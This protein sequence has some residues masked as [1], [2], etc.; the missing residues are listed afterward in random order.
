M[1]RNSTVYNYT[2]GA[3]L[4]YDYCFLDV[5]I[6]SKGGRSV[7]I[8]IIQLGNYFHATSLI[9]NDIQQ[10]LG[11]RA[12]SR[13]RIVYFIISTRRPSRSSFASSTQ[14]RSVKSYT[15]EDANDDKVGA[16][17]SHRRYRN[18]FEDANPTTLP[19]QPA[20]RRFLRANRKR[21]SRPALLCCSNNT[22]VLLQT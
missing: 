17:G 8:I 11:R 16:K 10:I 3:M 15:G 9:L 19:H 7:V 20:A 22:A 2:P 14:S 13:V 6:G 1:F 5:T 21:A 12:A 4:C 18:D